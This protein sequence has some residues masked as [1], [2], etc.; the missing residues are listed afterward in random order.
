MSDIIIGQNVQNNQ[1]W[2]RSENI[3]IRA[4]ETYFSV[5]S[6]TQVKLFKSFPLRTLFHELISTFLCFTIFL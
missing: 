1:S 3:N 4:G 5:V 2:I 6:K